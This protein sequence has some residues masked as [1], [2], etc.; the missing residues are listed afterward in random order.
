MIGPALLT[1]TS[2]D[3]PGS[4]IPETNLPVLD[5]DQIDSLSVPDQPPCRFPEERGAERFLFGFDL[6]RTESRL[7]ESCRRL[8]SGCCVSVPRRSLSR[9]DECVDDRVGIPFP[10]LP[11]SPVH[12]MIP[13]RGAYQGARIEEAPQLYHQRRLL[14]YSTSRTSTLFDRIAPDPACRRY[15]TPL[16][17]ASSLALCG[18]PGASFSARAETIPAS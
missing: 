18:A 7:I 3:I 16:T 8:E 13:P 12:P 4:D 14:V 6:G 17:T 9:L 1:R 15:P 11:E 5:L 2:P 10:L